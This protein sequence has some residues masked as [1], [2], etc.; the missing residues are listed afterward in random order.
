MPLINPIVS[1]I[2]CRAVS[3]IQQAKQA[4]SEGS[5]KDVN[6][7]VTIPTWPPVR[8]WNTS[9][10]HQT[11]KN[12]GSLHGDLRQVLLEPLSIFLRQHIRTGRPGDCLWNSPFP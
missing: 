12:P 1:E 2:L 7:E 4:A 5:R 3:V 6:L 11:N 8:E 9:G 10:R